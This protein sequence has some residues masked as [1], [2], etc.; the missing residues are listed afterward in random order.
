MFDEFSLG[1]TAEIIGV[2]RIIVVIVI[3]D[4]VVVDVATA[5]VLILGIVFQLGCK[6]G[7]NYI[8]QLV[9]GS[10]HFLIVFNL[11]RRTKSEMN[12][13]TKAEIFLSIS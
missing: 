12:E 10:F 4:I 9:R 3:V 7:N 13:G 5:V 11:I 1:D 6:R 8:F 2:V